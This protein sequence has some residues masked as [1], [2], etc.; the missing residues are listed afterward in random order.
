MCVCARVR[1]RVHARTHSVAQLCSTLSIPMD[2]GPPGSSVKRFS[3]QEY[4]SELPFPTP[5][6][7]P[8]PE[9][10]PESPVSPALAGGFFTTEPP[11]KPNCN[12]CSLL[13]IASGF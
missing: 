1:V 10:E 12:A 3:S 9:S 2:W 7:I 13:I 11:G 5:G 6:D 8:D 4:W